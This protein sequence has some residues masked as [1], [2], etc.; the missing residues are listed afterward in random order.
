MDGV[1]P[2]LARERSSIF[3]VTS[4]RI[5]G[6]VSM[7]QSLRSPVR[8]I[9]SGVCNLNTEQVLYTANNYV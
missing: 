7:I 4:Y 3:Y 6:I 5:G 1:D 2:S 8:A 9:F